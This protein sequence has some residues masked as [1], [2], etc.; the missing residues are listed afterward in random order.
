MNFIGFGAMEVTKSYEFIGFGAMEVT[1]PCEFIGFGSTEP[2][3]GVSCTMRR[4]RAVGDCL[5]ANIGETQ[6]WHPIDGHPYRRA[7]LWSF[8]EADRA[9]RG[10]GKNIENLRF[11]N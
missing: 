4:A 3:C 5:G 9:N 7:P 1:K 8:E 11:L 10:R 2:I 6:L